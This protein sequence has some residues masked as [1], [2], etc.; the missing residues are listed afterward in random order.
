MGGVSAQAGKAA[1]AAATAASTSAAL[2][3]AT[4][5]VTAPVAGL[6]TSCT[7]ADVP[8]AARPPMKWVMALGFVVMA[9]GR[10]R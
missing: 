7:R 1:W 8:A 2:A 9:G 3:R 6:V 4:R 10:G 5:P